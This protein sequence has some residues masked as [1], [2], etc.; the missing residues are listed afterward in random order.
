MTHDVR[1]VAAGD[2]LLLAELDERIDPVVNDR[3]IAAAAALR[4]QHFAGV[5]DIVPT[6]R[7]VAVHYDP[8]VADVD[9]LRLALARAASRTDAANRASGR[10]IEIPVCYDAEFA[11]DIDDVAGRT[12]LGRDRIIE[13]HTKRTYRVFMLGFL[14]GFAYLGLLDSRLAVPRLS[15]PRRE[16]PAGSVAIAGEQTGVYP[17]KSPGGWNVVGRTPVPM[18]SADR[19]EPSR[20]AA[21]DLVRFVP[22]DRQ[23]FDRI[24]AGARQ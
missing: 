7:S 6:F 16:V 24:A 22:I 1:I 3:A 13:L 19:A 17:R 10:Q 11:L 14:P 23:A 4:A 21:G 9:A 15:M 8:L 20:L 2:S 5:R 18:F 12:R